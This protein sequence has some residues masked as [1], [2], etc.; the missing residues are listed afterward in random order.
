MCLHMLENW[1]GLLLMISIIDADKQEK[2]SHTVL[3]EADVHKE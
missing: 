3:W 1:V 2:H